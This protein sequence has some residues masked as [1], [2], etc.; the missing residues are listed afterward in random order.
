MTEFE[1]STEGLFLSALSAGLDLGFGPLLIAAMLT[2]VS[3]VYSEPLTEIL[4]AN[5]YAVGFVFVVLGRTELSTEHTTL[6]VLPVLDRRASP[7]ELGRLWG[8][9]LGGNLVGGVIF[10]VVMV[11]VGPAFGIFE[12]RT[13]AAIA[14]PYVTHSSGALLGGALLAGWLMGL[15][16]W[17]VLAARDTISRV[18][19]VWLV[20]FVIGFGH[21]PYI[22]AGNIEMLAALLA[23]PTVTPIAYA[24]YLLIATV[25]NTIGGT[26]FVVLLKY[27]H[28]VRESDGAN[29]SIGRDDSEPEGQAEP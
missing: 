13:L 1:R 15:L 6:A 25:G 7:I 18:F 27:G 10:A 12:V 28:I 22:I 8:L 17:L 2:L 11:T 23:T 24:R 3:G 19:F 5:M 9:V 4:A 20:A 21:L 14:G 29:T 26:V 16:S